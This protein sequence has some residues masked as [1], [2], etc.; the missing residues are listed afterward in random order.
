[1]LGLDVCKI[2][3]SLSRLKQKKEKKV[4]HS[5]DLAPVSRFLSN[6]VIIYDGV[7]MTSLPVQV[8]YF[9]LESAEKL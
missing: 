3:P 1:M 8:G 7:D 4:Y 2:K 9:F 5:I 6:D